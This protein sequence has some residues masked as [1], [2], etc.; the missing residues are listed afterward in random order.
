M[1]VSI[2][3]WVLLGVMFTSM[4]VGLWRGLVYEVLSLV[5]WVAAFFLAQ[6]LATQRQTL[7]V[8]MCITGGEALAL[9]LIAAGELAEAL[10]GQRRRVS[11]EVWVGLGDRFSA[12]DQVQDLAARSGVTVPELQRLLAPN[13]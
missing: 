10:V 13:L 11:G 3:D 6:W 9:G 4:V 12:K 2:T 1:T 7:P 5:G 8:R